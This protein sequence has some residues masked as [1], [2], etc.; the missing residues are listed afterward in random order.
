MGYVDEVGLISDLVDLELVMAH[1]SDSR[2]VA[3]ADGSV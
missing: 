3:A 2:K 1:G